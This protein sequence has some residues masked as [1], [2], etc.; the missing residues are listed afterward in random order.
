MFFKKCEKKK[1]STCL[2][3]T[4][5]ALAAIGAFGLVHH[6]KMIAEGLGDKIKK[7]FKKAKDADVCPVE[8]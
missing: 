3:L 7:L 8:D 6:S 1:H 5:G 2:I 4:V